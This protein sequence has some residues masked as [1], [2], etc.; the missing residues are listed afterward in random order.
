MK[1]AVVTGGTRGIG[2]AI[3]EMLIKNGWRVFALFCEDTN[4]A[5]GFAKEFPGESLTVCRCDVSKPEEISRV[6]GEIGSVSL[7]VNNA[8]TAK[9]D[10]LTD[11]PD[12]TIH[13]LIDVDLT[14]TILCSKAVLPS[15]V[16]AGEGL[17]INI[18]SMWG[19]VGASC[20]AVYS[21]AKAGVI[22]FTKALAKEAAPSGI[23]VNCVS[24]GFIGTE[25]NSCLEPE[26][27]RE[28]VSDTPLGRAGTPRDVADAV[29]FLISEKAS[30]ITGEVIRVN[31]GLVI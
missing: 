4:S 7:L 26:V 11:L 18:S 17:I 25:M 2:K 19:E 5:N 20:E 21:A 22:G 8:G 15:M 24:P 13:R 29:E 6:F 30:F 10:I 9:I 12:E 28:I 27:F 1:T 16:R 3:S 14:G 23:R 31:G